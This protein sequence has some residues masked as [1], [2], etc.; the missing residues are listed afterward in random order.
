MKRDEQEDDRLFL[1]PISS[2]V[3]EVKRLQM[4]GRSTGIGMGTKEM[5]R[6]KDTL[7]RKLACCLSVSPCCD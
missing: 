2:T 5:G 7:Y 4:A 3:E 1:A 6:P